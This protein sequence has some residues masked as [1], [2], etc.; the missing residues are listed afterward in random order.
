MS[1]T[2]RPRAE[3]TITLGPPKLDVTTFVTVH[4]LLLFVISADQ[5]VPSLGAVGAPATLVSVGAALWWLTGRL[6]IGG[7]VDQDRQPLRLLLLVHAWYMMAS[8]LVVLTRPATPL[9]QTGSLRA[10]I[11]I[12]GLTGLA[13]LVCDGLTD[14]ARLRVLVDRLV[15]IA[16]GFALLGILQ[17]AT[18]LGFRIDVPGL[19]YNHE[20]ALVTHTR[21]IFTRPWATALHPIEFSVVTAAVL[22]IA[23]NRALVMAPGPRRNN[24]MTC[25]ALIALSVPL[26]ISR[27]GLV[28][29]PT[30]LLIVALGWNARQRLQAAILGVAS[31]PVLWLLVPGLIGTLIGMF[32]NTE[33]D[34][35]IQARVNRVPRIMALI[36]QRPWLGLGNG[37]FSVEDYFL[38]DNE[39]FITTLET[40]Y[41]G[42][43][44]T[45]VLLGGAIGMGL[46]LRYRPMAT[47]E[48]G[49]I[50]LACAATVA[51]I[52]L[53]LFTFDVFF[54][55]IVTAVLFVTMGM[56]GAL[57]RLTRAP[58][59][60]DA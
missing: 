21:G 8:Y 52:G 54:Y 16:T 55:R 28:V 37:T 31:I 2:A 53:A 47:Y 25:A 59:T 45:F 27:S 41:V 33:S 10:A 26:S 58:V 3:R 51:G 40:G 11:T 1:T 32:S 42:I 57:W 43:A 22:P 23:I 12:I 19:V 13:L 18:G 48:D 6:G 9:E 7:R 14:R 35:S 34:V 5:V 49:Q 39:F 17:W 29:L 20:G 38:V 15:L 60:T 4:L 36:R 24:A 46:W 44:L 30:A 56:I 50:G